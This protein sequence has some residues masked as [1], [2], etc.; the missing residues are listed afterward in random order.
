MLL[1]AGSES[2]RDIAELIF[3]LSHG[4]DACCSQDGGTR[5]LVRLSKCKTQP[6]CCIGWTHHHCGDIPSQNLGSLLANLDYELSEGTAN[7]VHGHEEALFTLCLLDMTCILHI[8]H[9][10]SLVD[11]NVKE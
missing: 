1:L 8:L 3:M 6:H 4:R 9:V 2:V 7:S 10:F 5:D 11:T